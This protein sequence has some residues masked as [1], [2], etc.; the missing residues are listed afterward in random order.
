M[1]KIKL[2]P[3]IAMIEL[4]FAIVI[5]GIVLMS[6]PQLISTANQSGYVTLQQEGIHEASSQMNL[7]LSMPWDEQNTNELYIP[8][9]LRVAGGDVNLNENA[10]TGRR[11]GTPSQSNRSFYRADGSAFFA[12]PPANLG[13]DGGDS[14]DM[15]D[16]NANSSLANQEAST[17]DYIETTTI[18]I[19][20]SV[21]Y[22][23]DVA[24]GGTYR[25]P[26]ADNSINYNPP[27]NTTAFGQTNIKFITVTLTSTAGQDE[28]NKTITLNAFAANIGG[29]KLEERIY[30]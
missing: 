22:G 1:Q 9:I 8:P 6:A 25:N 27:L 13:A 18:Q 5:L 28:L 10:S 2:R 17:S 11:A 20:S 16:F 19:A 30:P 29:Y 21:R 14:D 26:G 12:T 15:D 3:A 24:L 7:I 4:I 23:T